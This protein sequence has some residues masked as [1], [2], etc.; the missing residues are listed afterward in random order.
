MMSSTR[1]QRVADAFVEL[2]DTLVD[3]FD[4]ID[5][6]HTLARRCTELLDVE[7]AGIMLADHRGTLQT[8]AGSGAEPDV[9][10]L[11]ELQNEEGPSLDCFTTGVP[12]LDVRTDD[13]RWPDFGTRARELGYGG[14][15]AL[16]MRL[17]G[18]IVG[19]LALL[20]AAAGPLDSETVHLA[21]ALADVATISL[22]QQRSRRDSE[23]LVEQLQTALTSRIV[24]EQAKGI[25]AE[26]HAVTVDGAFDV[27]RAYARSHNLR[28]AEL[29]RRIIDEPDADA[30]MSFPVADKPIED[31]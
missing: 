25:L 18:R 21:Q 13:P 30:D 8:A 1:E 2:A 12:V 17:R 16:P 10:G 20:R 23:V 11:F 31:A 15:H 29:A 27:M 14:T 22:L 26:R 9:L 19:T 7:V 5:L 24:I 4:V 6:L 3:D 28:L